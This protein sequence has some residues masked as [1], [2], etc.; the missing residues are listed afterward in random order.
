ML[1]SSKI[2]SKVVDMTELN[3][4]PQ[5]SSPLPLDSLPFHWEGKEQENETTLMAKEDYQYFIALRTVSIMVKSGDKSIKVNALLDDGITK[6]YINLDEAAELGLHGKTEC[7]TVNVLNGQI[8]TFNTKPIEVLLESLCGNVRTNVTAFTADQVTGDMEAVNW[9]KYKR[10]WPHLKNIDFPCTTMRPRVD[11][12]VGLDCEDLHHAVE[13][14]RYRPGEPIAWLTHF[15]WTCIGTP[16]SNKQPKLQTQ[17][18][19]TFF[20][21]DQTE[22]EKMIMNLK[23]F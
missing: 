4:I 2:A 15:G 11:V 20:V 23:K 10:N 3:H 18:S 21:Q 13:E 6:T 17:C 1:S 14:V 12:L 9:N 19:S 22:L 5:G 16:G 8:K 7:V